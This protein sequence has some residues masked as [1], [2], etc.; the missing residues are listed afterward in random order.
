MFWS[1]CAHKMMITPP[2]AM[3][4][5]TPSNGLTNLFAN[6]GWC[7]RERPACR[8]CW[9]LGSVEG[10]LESLRCKVARQNNSAIQSSALYLNGAER[11]GRSWLC[12]T[13][14]HAR[15]KSRCSH[16]LYSSIKVG[17][18]P[19][20]LAGH[21]TQSIRSKIELLAGATCCRLG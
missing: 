5:S 17:S 14:T 1:N 7:K 4:A 9:I 18:L 15:W 2:A 16:H 13:K 11:R 6:C 3:V 10:G 12:A 8:G 21:S 20:V 19:I